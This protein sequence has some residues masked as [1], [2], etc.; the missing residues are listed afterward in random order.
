MEPASS[1]APAQDE[2]TTQAAGAAVDPVWAGAAPADAAVDPVPAGEGANPAPA[3][4]AE[5]QD[6]V[7]RLAPKEGRRPRDMIISLLVLLVPIALVMGFYRVVLEGDR[8]VSIDPASSIDLASRQFPV[9]VP[10][11]LTEDQ[12]W[13]VTSA[14][15]RRENDG[16]TLRL[17]YVPPSDKAILMIQSSVDPSILVPAEVG[18]Q[19]QRTGTFRT[20]QR[21]WLQYSGRTGE[22][23]LIATEPDRTIVL[24]GAS[25]DTE[26]LEKLATAL[27]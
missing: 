23:A 22:T 8:P 21:T 15:F 27:P 16:A 3:V 11:G 5:E 19:G 4:E 20:D 10:V 12:D 9:T 14:N 26:N 18:K 25:G 17:G 2:T 7:P 13:H 6:P 1:P 24:I